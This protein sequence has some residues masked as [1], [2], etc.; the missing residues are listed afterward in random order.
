MEHGGDTV[1]PT[2]ITRLPRSLGSL[3]GSQLPNLMP[4]MYDILQ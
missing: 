4:I 3:S 2:V 1:G